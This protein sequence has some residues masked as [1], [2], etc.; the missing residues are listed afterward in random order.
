M[1]IEINIADID[2]NLDEKNMPLLTKF[3]FKFFGLYN[4]LFNKKNNCC[5]I[6]LKY[7]LTLIV[8]FYLS[9][10]MAVILNSSNNLMKSFIS[11]IIPMMIMI[12]YLLFIY[13]PKWSKSKELKFLLKKREYFNLFNKRI[14]QLSIIFFIIY[15]PLNILMYINFNEIQWINYNRTDFFPL[16][17]QIFAFPFAFIFFT[18]F[19]LIISFQTIASKYTC[20]LIK[21]YLGNLEKILS[22]NNEE[23]VIYKICDKQN[24]LEL[25]S[26]NLNKLTSVCNGLII[27]FL[28]F[29]GVMSI[30]KAFIIFYI[31]RT[32]AYIDVFSGFFY[33][34]ITLLI[35]YNLSQW[36]SSYKKYTQK[37]KNKAEVIPAIINNFGTISSFNK[38]LENHESHAARLFGASDG[39]RINKD[40]YNKIITLFGSLFTFIIGYFNNN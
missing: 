24:E 26:Y 3:I 34:A 2:N 1:S 22:D 29:L 36:N 31:S 8:E 33:F 32:E 37:W 21:N 38:W 9:S 11:L 13:F 39:I 35:L 10:M 4:N 28:L 12:F 20:N 14:L 19:S 40:L 6:S 30:E 17:I 16:V 25:W 15:V 23:K 7:I 5:N 27:V 18:A